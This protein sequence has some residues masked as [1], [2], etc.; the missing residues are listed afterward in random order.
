VAVYA[1]GG[2][3]PRIHPTSSVHPLASVA[4]R[5]EIGPECFIG[6]GASLRGD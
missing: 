1:I 4:G 2:N 3:R 6:T 5:V